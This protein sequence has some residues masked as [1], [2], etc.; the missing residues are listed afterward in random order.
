MMISN[1]LAISAIAASYT[2][3][4]YVLLTMH[5]LISTNARGVFNESVPVSFLHKHIK[6]KG[7]EQKKVLE[8]RY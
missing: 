4:T 1:S 7:M 6:K 5:G 2:V 3:N 8:Q